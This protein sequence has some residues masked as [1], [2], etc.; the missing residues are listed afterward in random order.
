MDGPFGEGHQTWWD[1]EVVVLVA[2]G[3]GVTPF[4]SI[5]RDMVNRLQNSTKMMRTKQASSFSLLLK[6]I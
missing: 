2:G 6:V 1:Y 4:A 3:I 5:L